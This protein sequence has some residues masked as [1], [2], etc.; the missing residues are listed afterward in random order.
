MVI[1]HWIQMNVRASFCL[2]T[3]NNNQNNLVRIC[4]LLKHHLHLFTV[5]AGLHINKHA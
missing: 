4:Q 3:I 2:K 1:L 5:Y